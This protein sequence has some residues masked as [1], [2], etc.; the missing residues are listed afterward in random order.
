MNPKRIF[1]IILT[2]VILAGFFGLGG[3]YFSKNSNSTESVIFSVEKGEGSKEIALNLEKKGL[4]W[5]EPLFRAYVL[6]TGYS[7]KLQAGSYELNPSMNVPQIV[8]KFVSGDTLKIKITIPEGF[9]LKQ[10]EDEFSLELPRPA[11]GRFFAADFKSEFDFLNDAPAGA[12]LEGFLF[13]DTYILELLIDDKEIAESFLKNFNNK[14][15]QDFRVEIKK[16][17]KKIFEIVTMTSLIEKEVKTK[18]DKE[19]VSGIL[20]KRLK[21]NI[22]LQV[23]A[24]IG[25]ITGKKSTEISIDETKIDSPYNTYRYL[26]LPKGP[27]C[28]PGI[29]SILAAIYPQN[30]QYWYYLSTPE[31]KTIFSKTLEEH[32]IAKAKYLK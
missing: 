9:N 14:L 22:P 6:I 12:S 8:R 26:G 31:G 17:N 28:N 16:Q 7:K 11:L 21:N 19:I 4:I 20:W 27:I 13:P 3:I 25:Y 23:D 5:W 29:E 30:S 10:I 18:E 2:I 15:T 1:L 24:T 32:N